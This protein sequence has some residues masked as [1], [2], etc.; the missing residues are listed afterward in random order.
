[1]MTLLPRWRSRQGAI[2]GIPL[3]ERLFEVAP[4][5]KILGRCHWQP[6]AK[7]HPTLLL[8]HGFEGCS[9]SHYMLGIAGKAWRAGFNV[10]R[11]N[12]RNC[13][14]TEHLTSTLYHSGTS[15][16]FLSIAQELSARDGIE[17]IW[18]AGYSMGGNLALQ[19]AGCAGTLLPTLKGVAVVCP[20]IHP[21]AAV[22]A[23]ER[24]RNWIYHRHFLKSLQARMRRKAS[25]F[26]GRFDLSRLDTI[27]SLREFDDVYTAPAGGYA[28]AAD[29][30][31]RT[32]SRHVLGNIRV[33]TLIITAQDDPFI[34]YGCFDLPA[35]R[36]NP[37]IQLVVPPH[38][39]HCGFIQRPRPDEDL[40]W[41]ENRIIEF[42][43][44]IEAQ[45]GRETR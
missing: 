31:E 27:R 32:G 8:I 9:E 41:A 26:P 36:E 44:R 13:G 10:V 43:A 1:M 3:E 23:L 5:S 21:A 45:T 33:P 42:M 19:V 30:Y 12:Q 17:A 20:N 14:G 24:P 37:W 40:Y 39:G 4:E 38:G 28:G 29:Y 22:D 25:V 6:D 34:P 7:R 15:G 2:E 11:L 18:L 35:L 16:D